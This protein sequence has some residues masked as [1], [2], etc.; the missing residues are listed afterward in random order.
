MTATLHW[1]KY[2][3][4][5]FMMYSGVAIMLVDTTE[6]APGFIY[7]SRSALVVIGIIFFLS[8]LTLFVG[9]LTKQRR[10]IGHG[11]FMVYLCFLFTTLLSWIAFGFT[12]ALGNIIA[13]LI[14]GGLYLRWKYHIYYYDPVDKPHKLRYSSTTTE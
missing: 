5:V 9:K 3:V 2:I 12:A 6:P 8:G 13:T 11:L 14:T 7:N 4:A 1:F 10:T